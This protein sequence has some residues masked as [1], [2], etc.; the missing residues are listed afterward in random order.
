VYVTDRHGVDAVRL[1]IAAATP[2]GRH[3][4]SV[5]GATLDYDVPHL[6]MHCLTN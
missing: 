3:E 4:R 5:F 6:E 2:A 1:T